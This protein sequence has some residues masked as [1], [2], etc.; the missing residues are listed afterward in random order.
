MDHDI[1][2]D[3]NYN[4]YDIPEDLK[5]RSTDKHRQLSNA[6]NRYIENEKSVAFI[7]P[8]LKKTGQMLQVIRSNIQHGEKTPKG[9][10][11]NKVERDKNVCKITDPLLYL[12]F[13]EIFNKPEYRLIVY[14]TLLPGNVNYKILEHYKGKW[15]DGKI[16][17]QMEIID[18]YKYFTWDSS[19]NETTVKIIETTEQPIEF[20][21]LDKFEGKLYK[22]ILIPVN[23]NNKIYI[24]Y[25]YTKNT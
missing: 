14:G 4:P 23:I 3:A 22:K 1:L 19:S 7:D 21:N 13:S 18:N 5:K 10:D 9:P 6:F 2:K 15:L 8:L 16:K 24:S 12:L 11:S 20:K 17:G 25:I